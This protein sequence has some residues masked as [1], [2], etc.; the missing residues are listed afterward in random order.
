L[1]A[2]GHDLNYIALSGALGSILSN[3]RL[4]RPLNLV[5]DF[6]GGSMFVLSGLL[7]ALHERS[8]SG[9][10]QVVDATMVDGTSTLLTAIREL[11][12]ND[13]CQGQPGGNFL[14]GGAHFYTNYE[15]ADGN[16]VS[17]EPIEPQFYRLLC[18]RFDLFERICGPVE[19][20]GLTTPVR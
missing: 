8:V 15:C 12:G 5:D 2:A 17:I 7:A 14:D 3:G 10:G 6:A 20:R 16:Y 13:L 9:R 1:R 19:P 18:R 4:V 11:H